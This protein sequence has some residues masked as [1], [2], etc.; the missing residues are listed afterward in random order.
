MAIA[1]QTDIRQTLKTPS[2]W[3]VILH[4]DDFTPM[5]FVTMVLVDIFNKTHEEAEQLM[6]TV[7]HQGKAN[8]G[9]FTKEVAVTKATQVR[10]VA[11]AHGHPLEA[12]PEEA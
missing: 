11:E 1:T 2:M 9:L 6:L 10:M 3:K 8:V 7:H 4:N 12:T 5:D